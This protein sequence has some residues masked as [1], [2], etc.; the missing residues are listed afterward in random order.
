VSK[1]FEVVLMPPGQPVQLEAK[2][3]NDIL[4]IKPVKAYCL[5][6]G[7][8]D[9]KPSYL[10]VMI[11]AYGETYVTQITDAMLREGLRTGLM[12]HKPSGKQASQDRL[13]QILSDDL[14]QTRML[15]LADDQKIA[16]V[17]AQRTI[18]QL[19][20]EEKD[21]GMLQMITAVYLL[22]EE[23]G[24]KNGREDGSARD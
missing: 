11:D 10:F 4:E 19:S 18:E 15:A 24:Y 7:A 1:D 23:N 6:N 21:A 3:G 13:S 20:E 5:P 17:T 22:G 2:N 8:T 14:T 9:N 12:Q 16:M